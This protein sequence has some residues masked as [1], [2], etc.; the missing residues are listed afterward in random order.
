MNGTIDDEAFQQEEVLA[1]TAHSSP[2]VGDASPRQADEIDDVARKVSETYPGNKPIV[3]SAGKSVVRRRGGALRTVWFLL[4]TV[5]T[6]AIAVV[7]V[8]VALVTW[9]QYNDGPWTR[10]GRVRVQV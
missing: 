4:R 5:A 6:A 10:D 7:A 2:G 8:L 9:D 3:S 1:L